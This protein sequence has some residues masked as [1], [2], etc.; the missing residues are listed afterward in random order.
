MSDV[1]LKDETPASAPA[2]MTA[3]VTLALFAAARNDLATFVS[4][5]FAAVEPGI[6]YLSNWHIRAITDALE[7]VARGEC[8]RLIITM[9]P[10]SLKS[11]TA[12]VAFPAWLLGRD[13]TRKFI[14]VSYAQPLAVKHANDFRTVVD[15]AWY[16]AMFPVFRVSPRKN[17]ENE[18]QTTLGGG[19]LATSTGGQLTGR[20]GDIIIIDDPLKAD[21]AHSELARKKC[22]EW[23]RTTLMSR[24]NSPRDGAVV[25]VMQR[26]H[27]DDLAGVLLETGGWEHLNLPA[28]AEENQRVPLGNGRFHDRKVGD[29][30][31]PTRLGHAELERL[32]RDLGSLAFSAQYQQ[33]PAPSDGNIIKRAWFRHYDPTQLDCSA[34]TIVQSW[35]TAVKGD[36]S[37]D[38]SVGTTWATDQ[39]NFYLLDVVRIRAAYPE[40]VKAVK[41]AAEKHHP[42]IILIEDTGSGSSLIADLDSQGMSTTPVKDKADKESRVHRVTAMLE[43]GNVYLPTVAHWKDDLLNEVTAFPAAKYDDQVDSMTQ[44]LKWMKDD[45]RTGRFWIGKFNL[46]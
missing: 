37:C 19:R 43:N 23:V 25:L 20:G 40:L 30:L 32:R 11:L 44:A 27:V 45:N 35:D 46:R 18:L 24:F 9:P 8:K 12:S 34:M 41:A 4:L 39:S 22:A 5:A 3:Q 10:R 1:L 21:E 6:N 13:P 14:C 31:H 33:S 36:P 38:Y 29:L 15:T 26:L 2:A 17:T 7:R 28:I 16:R 42:D